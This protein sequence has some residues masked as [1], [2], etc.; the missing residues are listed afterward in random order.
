VK[1]SLKSENLS[2][3]SVG[4]YP[5]SVKLS[6]LSADNSLSSVTLPLLSVTLPLLSVKPLLP[7]EILSLKAVETT[8]PP[9]NQL[10]L[11]APPVLKI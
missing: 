6:L 9:A 1:H 10:L 7:S 4:R 3:L 5:L 2:L 11:S 8:L